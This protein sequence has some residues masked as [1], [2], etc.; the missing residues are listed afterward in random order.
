VRGKVEEEDYRGLL[1]IYPGQTEIQQSLRRLQKESHL[2]LSDD[3]LDELD[4]YAKRIRGEVLFAR[5]WILCE[6]QSEYVLI[7]CF[8]DLLARPLD[9]AGVTVID[10]QNNGSPGA[11]VGLARAFDI[12]WIM[13]C[14]NDQEGENF[15]E[16]IHKRGL[17]TQEIESLVLKLPGA[18]VR[19]EEFLV[20]NGLAP[21]LRR[22]LAS[23]GVRL[24]KQ[25]GE[26]GCEE[27]MVEHLRRDKTGYAL[28]L[29]N[30]LRESGADESRVPELFRSLISQITQRTI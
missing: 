1:R 11:F 28:A 13:I 10:F 4:T 21:E 25:Q 22:V 19:L 16:Q 17:S 26:E 5:A 8:A 12:P 27:E 29:V 7:K 6:G 2:Y 14:D 20:R 23:K 30:E 9:R 15:V 3:E 18:G 24:I